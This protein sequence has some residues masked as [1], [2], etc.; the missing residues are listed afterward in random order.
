MWYEVERLETKVGRPWLQD[1]GFRTGILG[2]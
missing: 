2:Q 1:W